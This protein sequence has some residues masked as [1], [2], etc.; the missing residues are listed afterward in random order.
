M[1]LVLGESLHL[2][3]VLKQSIVKDLEDQAVLE[4]LMKTVRIGIQTLQLRYPV[5]VGAAS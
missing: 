1:V 2:W 4:S 5:E 3:K